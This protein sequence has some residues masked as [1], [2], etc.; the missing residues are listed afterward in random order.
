[1]V[2]PGILVVA[3]D[4]AL[5]ATLARWLLQGG[6]AVEERFAQGGEFLEIQPARFES[7]RQ[8]F[9]HIDKR[10]N[11]VGYDVERVAIVIGN[12]EPEALIPAII[13]GEGA[14]QSSG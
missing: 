6:Y 4:A 12:G 8:S 5:R 13:I 7:S 2:K 11:G 9:A 3:D 1:M 14:L 10:F